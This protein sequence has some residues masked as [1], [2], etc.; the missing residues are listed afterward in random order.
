MQ[1]ITGS[2]RD[3]KRTRRDKEEES[4]DG[5]AAAGS[6]EDEEDAFELNLD[7]ASDDD[8]FVD[9]EDDELA[10]EGARILTNSKAE[11]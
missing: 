7:E 8:D 3:S 4:K 9:R 6:E 10:A 11:G 5:A 1:K 2:K